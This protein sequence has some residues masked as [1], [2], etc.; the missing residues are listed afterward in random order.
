MSKTIMKTQFDSM[1]RVVALSNLEAMCEH[2]S[3]T[4]HKF[5]I[6]KTTANSVRVQYSNPDEYGNPEPV[7][8]I[9]PAWKD[10]DGMAVCLDALRYTG[11]TGKNEEAWQAFYQLTDCPALSRCNPDSDDWRTA[12]QWLVEKHP[13][14]AVTSTWDKD[15]CIQTWHC[16]DRAF[17]SWLDAQA[18]AVE[19]MKS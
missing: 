16:K 4:C 3:G 9:Y 2:I 14:F 15:G 18:W 12:Y 19:Q 1:K 5:E 17:Q 6:V 10:Y 11:C 7:T 13:E 8:A